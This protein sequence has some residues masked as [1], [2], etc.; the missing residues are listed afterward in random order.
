MPRIG[1]DGC[2]LQRVRTGIGRYVFELCRELD[3]ALPTAQFFV[4]SRAPVALPVD[5]PRWNVRVEPRKWATRLPRLVWLKWRCGALAR[6]DDLDVFWATGTML[7][8]LARRVRTVVTVYDLNH[9]LVPHTMAPINLWAYRLF[10][11]RDVRRAD[12]VLPISSGTETRLRELVGRPANGVVR[13]C[14]GD[15]FRRYTD[16]QVDARLSG[17]GIRRPYLLAVA[18]W[19]PRKNLELLVRTYLALKRDGL[20]SGHMLVLVGGRGWKDARLEALIGSAARDEIRPLGFVD[21]GDLPYLYA[22]ADV[23]VFPSAYEGFGI[24]VLEARLCGARVV[25][26]DIPEIREAGGD[27]VSYCEPTESSLREA[28]VK[29]VGGARPAVSLVD[30]PSWAASARILAAALAA[31]E[32]D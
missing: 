5:S 4:Y 7:P 23:F 20:L 27:G 15:E 24:P 32:G 26:T 25:A 8:R 14:A 28:I 13:P 17:F 29:A 10:F 11:D 3:A 18:T 30:R 9:R 12:V 2:P 19:E 21:D 31:G 1:I 6:G 22:G 16:A